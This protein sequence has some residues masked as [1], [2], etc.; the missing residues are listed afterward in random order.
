MGALCLGSYL[1]CLA[2]AIASWVLLPGRV[3]THFGPSGE[4]DGWASPTENAVIFMAIS[5]LLFVLFFFMHRIIAKVP[6]SLINLPNK[7]Y[8]LA[9]ERA[10]STCAVLAVQFRVFGAAILLLLCVAQALAV[11]ANLTKPP[12]LDN[13]LFLGALGLF[14]VFTIVWA[15]SFYRAFRR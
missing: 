15:V 6:V 1:A 3:A 8:W 2:I 5:T 11:Q 12:K 14:F 13:A 9:P 4:P 10:A 7:E